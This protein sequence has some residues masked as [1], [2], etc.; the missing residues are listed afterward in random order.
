[1][2]LQD[3][4]RAAATLRAAAR[5]GEA[6]HDDEIRARALAWLVGVVGFNLEKPPEALALADDAR[7]A[8]ERLGGDLYV[9]SILE[10]SLGRTYSRTTDYAKMLEHHE[11]SLALRRKLFGE[12]DPNTAAG[13]NN[14]GAAFTQLGRYR[15]GLAV[16]RKAQGIREKVLGP[17]HPDTAMSD[18]NIGA[19]EY[20]LGDLG[21]ALRD[22]DI[23]LAAAKRSSL[24]PTHM[25]V[26]I[27]Q[28]N[29]A[30][31]EGE[32]GHYAEAQ[33]TY[34]V[35]FSTLRTKQ[36]HSQRML[37]ALSDHA[38]E[39]LVP[40]GHAE[41]ALAEAE[42][43]IAIASAAGPPDDD[44][45][46]AMQ[47]KGHALEAL[48]K[49][50]AALATYRAALDIDEKL[51]GHDDPKILDILGGIGTVALAQHHPTDAAV[52]FEHALAIAKAHDIGGKWRA[53]LE[54][55]LAR[56]VVTSDPERARTLATSARAWYAS[57]PLTKDLAAI[58]ALLVSLTPAPRR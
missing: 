44:A 48:G 27:A 40:T 33:V 8:L 57:S 18:T 5:A 36:P 47:A 13:Y 58:D 9:E 41:A 38:N 43:A 53:R 34:D 2:F 49:L 51:L 46:Y 29:H 28:L 55:G 32:L 39:V 10:S 16:H 42:Q 37:R 17:E 23:G 7:A 20:E 25:T 14:V 31:I 30:A 52:A 11:S 35:L 22:S 12:D 4:E 54:F 1:V 21:A 56:A 45:A 24:P 15:E 3:G 50:D 6:G 19:S 26:L